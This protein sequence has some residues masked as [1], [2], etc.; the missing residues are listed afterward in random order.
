[1]TTPSEQHER[2]LVICN[3]SIPATIALWREAVCRPSATTGAAK[4]I[5]WTP[6]ALTGAASAAVK[7]VAAICGIDTIV[8]G[9]ASAPPNEQGAAWNAM[10]LAAG[11]EAMRHNVS[12][13]VWP[14]HVE[15]HDEAAHDER[16]QEAIT[17][18][19]DRALL[20]ARLLSV[21]AVPPSTGIIETPFVDL[22]DVQL[23]DLAADL[24]APVGAAWWCERGVG[25]HTGAMTTPC[26]VCPSCKRWTAAMKKA[27]VVP[28]IAQLPK[29]LVEQKPANAVAQSV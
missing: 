11:A 1:M 22:N 3:G 14:V 25:G 15:G 8:T 13:I 5:V 10:L 24:D 27:G 16:R 17:K 4:P 20:A 28:T 6:S 29:A 26:G 9:T 21:D 19:F 7:R 12:R 23:L 2:C 18:A